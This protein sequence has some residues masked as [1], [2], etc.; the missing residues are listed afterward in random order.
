MEP[1]F[2]FQRRI[3]IAD[4][5]PIF[6]HLEIIRQFDVNAVRIDVHRRRAVD[7]LSDQLEGGPTT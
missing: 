1:L 4:T 2:H 5:K 6:R 3:W 7:R